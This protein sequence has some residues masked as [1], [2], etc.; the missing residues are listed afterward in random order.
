MKWTRQNVLHLLIAIGVILILSCIFSDRNCYTFSENMNNMDGRKP[1]FVLFHWNQCG[2]CKQMM[3]EWLKLKQKYSQD[4]RIQIVEIERDDPEIQQHK[5]SSFPTIRFFNQ[6][7][8]TSTQEHYN[9]D[10]EEHEDYEGE[11]TV[12]HMSNFI[13]GILAKSSS[14]PARLDGETPAGSPTGYP[15][16]AYSREADTMGLN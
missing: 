7:A 4:P 15:V 11:R 2:H 8:L 10:K 14:M 1:A 16:R 6:P 12:G 9:N 13:E 5:I 3:P